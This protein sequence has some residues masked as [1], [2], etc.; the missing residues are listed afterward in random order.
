M[1]SGGQLTTGQRHRNV[2]LMTSRDGRIT[3]TQVFFGGRA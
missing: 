3:E 1:R 2:E